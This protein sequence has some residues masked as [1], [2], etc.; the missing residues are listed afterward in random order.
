MGLK[1]S[2]FDTQ[3]RTSTDTK[4]PPPCPSAP[5]PE[6]GLQN[7]VGRLVLTLVDENGQLAV[8]RLAL[9][10]GVLVGLEG[11]LGTGARQAGVRLRRARGEQGL[12]AWEKA[13]HKG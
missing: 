13:S 7:F 12:A 2:Y 5:L 8:H 9:L 10:A 11:T 6:Q 3:W 4:W 1:L